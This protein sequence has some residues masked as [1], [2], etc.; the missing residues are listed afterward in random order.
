MRSLK[1]TVSLIMAAVTAALVMPIVSAEETRADI[2]CDKIRMFQS[3]MYVAGTIVVGRGRTTYLNFTMPEGEYTKVELNL[4]REKGQA[5]GENESGEREYDKAYYRIVSIDGETGVN[6]K[7]EEYI[8]FTLNG[9]GTEDQ[10]IDITDAVAEYVESSEEDTFGIELAGYYEVNQY[11]DNGAWEGDEKYCYCT[12]DG[13]SADESTYSEPSAEAEEIMTDYIPEIRT[14]TITS[15]ETEFEHPGVLLNKTMLD[16]MVSKVRAGEDPWYENYQ[17]MIKTNEASLDPL[18]YIDKTEDVYMEIGDGIYADS[19]EKNI[20]NYTRKDA[21]TAFYQAAMYLITGNGQFRQNALDI[22]EAFGSMRSLGLVYDEQI[23]YSLIAYKLCAAAEMLKY[24]SV[25]DESLAWDDEYEGY[26]QNFI[27]LTRSKWDR[28]SHWMNQH[29]M[30]VMAQTAVGIYNNDETIYNTGVLRGTTN[31]EYCDI[32]GCDHSSCNLNRSGAIKY[33]FREVTFNAETGEPTE[34]NLQLAE[35][36]RDQGHSYCDVAA[37]SIFAMMTWLQG[38]KVDNETGAVS[39]AD[40]AVYIWDYL[41]ERIMKTVNLCFKYNEGYEIEWIPI[42]ETDGQIYSEINKQYSSVGNIDNV[43]GLAYIYYRYYLGRED[44][45]T[46]EDTKYLSMGRAAKYGTSTA[47]DWIGWVDLFITPADADAQF[48]QKDT[49]HNV[50]IE[51]VNCTYDTENSTAAFSDLVTINVHADEGYTL[52][53]ATVTVNGE[54]LDINRDIEYSGS[55]TE[56]AVAFGMPQEDAHVVIEPVELPQ[57]FNDVPVTAWY[58]DG[59]RSAFENGLM[60][61][62]SETEF[63]PDGTFSRAMLVSTLY[64][65]AGEPEVS[66]TAAFADVPD[67]AWYEDALVWAVE[68]GIVNGITE[69]AF[70]PDAPV[71]RQDLAVMLLRYEA[72]ETVE[73]AEL[74]GFTDA[75]D[76]ADYAVEAVGAA[77]ESGIMSGVTD[78]E[79]MPRENVTRAQAALMLTRQIEN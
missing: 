37:S 63:V 33:L 41:D 1:R 6:A 27:E 78:T 53:D 65:M 59:V 40:D 7:P 71:T 3:G 48:T 51:G 50:S 38:T 54:R 75:G 76:I 11:D 30:C 67:G 70:A 5:W 2:A 58:Y 69:T 4:R 13:V 23:G 49:Q 36:G 66:G 21:D 68:N 73:T 19:H 72:P 15:G 55:D 17:S 20:M 26:M 14:E 39:T 10:K 64:R 60:N 22:I 44:M 45:D 12:F 34:P 61:G 43:A 25:Q 18:V 31:P 56:V 57:R 32:E 24:S 8:E 77:V 16:T 79:L 47:Q 42:Y 29:L 28:Y 46:N 62:V 74:D 35:M 52:K 9:N